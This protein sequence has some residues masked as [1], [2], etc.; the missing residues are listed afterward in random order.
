MEDI[1]DAIPAEPLT[2]VSADE[3]LPEPEAAPSPAAEMQIKAVRN[4]LRIVEVPVSYRKRIAGESKVS[5]DLKASVKAAMR[6][7]G[8]FFRVRRDG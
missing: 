5:G 6:I 1:E 2:A 3:L 4:G 8:V 7:L